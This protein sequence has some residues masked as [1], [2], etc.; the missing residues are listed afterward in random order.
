MLSLWKAST[1]PATAWSSVNQ[2]AGN[3]QADALALIQS[4][5]PPPDPLDGSSNIEC[6]VAVGSIF[7]IYH[8][9]VKELAE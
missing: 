1:M 2:P 5:D 3:G 8:T 7:G 4:P 6:N 9:D